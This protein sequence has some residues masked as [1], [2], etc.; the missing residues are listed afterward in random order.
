[1]K[2]KI[3]N[4]EPEPEE[5]ALEFWLEQDALGQVNLKAGRGGIRITLLGFMEANGQCYLAKHQEQTF[6][7]PCPYSLD[8][9]MSM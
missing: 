8:F 5:P 9:F 7:A 2:F 6:D 4:I 3:R 1:M